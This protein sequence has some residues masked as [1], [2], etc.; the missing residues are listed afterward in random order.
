MKVKD[1]DFNSIDGKYT[2]HLINTD[3]LLDQLPNCLGGKTGFTYE[4]GKSLMMAAHHPANK[5]QKVIAV[6]LDD[7]YRWEDMK[8]LFEWTFSV[9]LWPN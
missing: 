7:N 6:L 2:H 4:A 3:I 5:D 8:N 9:Y 1:K